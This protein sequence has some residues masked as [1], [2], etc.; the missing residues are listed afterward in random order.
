M[1]R[2]TVKKQISEIIKNDGFE[3]D[4]AIQLAY[5]G[6]LDSSCLLHVLSDLKEWFNFRLFVTYVNYNTSS[7]SLK[8]LKEL[9]KISSDVIVSTLDVQIEPFE[10]FESKARDV[11]YSFFEKISK[12]HDINY[13]VT[14]H[15]Y[16]DQVETLVMK[17]IDGS[18]VIGMQGIRKIAG[19][20]FRPMLEIRKRDIIEYAKKNKIYYSQD[21]SN[22]DIS[23]RRNKIRKVI[24]PS[25]MK[26]SF[27]L[28]KI[29]DLGQK[30]IL[31]FEDL[32]KEIFN[33]I[34][35]LKCESYG[36]FKFISFNINRVINRDVVYVKLLFKLILQKKF[37]LKKYNKNK[38]FWIEL[39]NFISTA[40]TG[41]FFYMSD[42]VRVLKDRGNIVIFD[43]IVL[44]EKQV[45]R[46]KVDKQVETFLG[47]IETFKSSQTKNLRGNEYILSKSKF[48]EG[49]FVRNWK[50][51]D[52]VRFNYGSK[53]VSDLFIDF[54][55]PF[56]KKKIYPI[57]EDFNGEIIWIP[58]MYS[59]KLKLSDSKILLRWNG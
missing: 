16:E 27:L 37:N 24:I 45:S 50:E 28:K 13:T 43:N 51:G 44:N 56:I 47:N 18:D 26:D 6:G 33:E 14:A 40:K 41:A 2:E 38:A 10:N 21:P 29:E 58:E 12:K 54:K 25:L 17:F 3:G 48:D 35:N 55:L 23:F 36:N 31:K 9:D 8:V 53:K 22:Q 59:K 4:F 30:S 19:T 5:S 20:L 42:E 15:H 46:V 49:I 11:R 34:D 7:Y 57:I 52:K 39:L 32:K 1:L